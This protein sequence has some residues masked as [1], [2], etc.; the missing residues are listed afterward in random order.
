MV[1]EAFGDR[2]KEMYEIRGLSVAPEIHGHGYGTAL[3]KHV[4]ERVREEQSLLHM[5]PTDSCSLSVE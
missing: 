2:V 3:V 4:L 5:G 1:R